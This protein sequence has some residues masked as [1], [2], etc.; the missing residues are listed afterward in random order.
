M[1]G[2]SVRQGQDTLTTRRLPASFDDMKVEEFLDF[3]QWW[4]ALSSTDRQAV[5]AARKHTLH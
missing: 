1:A 3:V 5:L 2:E 4:A